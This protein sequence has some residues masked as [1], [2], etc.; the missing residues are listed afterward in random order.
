MIPV[1]SVGRGYGAAPD[2]V[3]ARL[4]IDWGTFGDLAAGDSGAGRNLMAATMR[5][6]MIAAGVVSTAADEVLRAW[7]GIAPTIQVDINEYA[8]AAAPL[9]PS[10][11]PIDDA[12]V[13]AAD[14]A[15]A[16][17]VPTSVDRRSGR[18]FTACVAPGRRRT[19]TPGGR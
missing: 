4:V 3:T 7:Q 19:W 5:Q 6:V 14:R 17:A 18:P 11:W 16:A 9:L 12:L 2:V 1:V 8:S 13:S 15:V 10:P